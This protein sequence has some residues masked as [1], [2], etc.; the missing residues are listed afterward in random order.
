MTKKAL[1]L[2]GGGARGA[3]QAGVL[4]AIGHILHEKTLPFD[5]ISGVSVGSINAAILAENA[6]DFPTA[7]EKLES[8]WSEI[9]CQ[10]IYKASNYEL[11][12]SVLRNLS[13]FIIKQRQSGHLLDTNPLKN[14]LEETIDFAK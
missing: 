9:H 10:Q 13:T 5:M 1:Y 8:I 4:K 3:Y 11:S 14:F 12:K 2:A 6:D 7:L